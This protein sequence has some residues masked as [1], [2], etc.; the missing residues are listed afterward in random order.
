M[1]KQRFTLVDGRPVQR[2][3][4]RASDIDVD[5][6]IAWICIA[7]AGIAVAFGQ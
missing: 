4:R 5:K 6:V 1:E 2:L 3:R 7:L